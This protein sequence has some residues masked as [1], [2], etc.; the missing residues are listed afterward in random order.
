MAAFTPSSR[1]LTGFDMALTNAILFFLLS[2]S[3]VIFRLPLG[4]S[5]FVGVV[6][7]LGSIVSAGTMLFSGGA[8]AA[9]VFYVL[10]CG[11]FFGFGT[12]YSTTL[13]DFYTNAFFSHATQELMVPSMNLINSLSVTIALVVA[14]PFC[15]QGPGESGRYTKLRSTLDLLRPALPFA[16]VLSFIYI[17]LLIMTFPLA[18]DPLLRSLITYMQ[19]LA[20][21]AVLASAAI[22]S[23]ASIGTRIAASVIVGVLSAIGLI[24]F[25]KQQTM[26]P[27]VALI[28]GLLLDGQARRAAM[29]ASAAAVVVYMFLAVPVSTYGRVH[30]NYNPAENSIGERL[31]MFDYIFERNSTEHDQG[32]QRQGQYVARF[33]AAPVQAFLIAQH[34]KGNPGD[35][36][37]QGWIALVPRVLWSDKPNVTRFGTELDSSV[38][39]RG[40]SAS[41]LAPSYSGEAYWNGG[42]VGLILVSALLGLE[43]GWLTRKWIKFT[44]VGLREAGIFIFGVP[45][46][47]FSLWVETWIVPTY[48]GGFATLFV[49]ITAANFAVRNLLP[50]SH[51]A[52]ISASRRPA[53]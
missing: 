32:R 4:F 19:G 17:V 11:I 37:A 12:V 33:S 15:R 42:W 20:F 21:C 10:G 2:F 23:T 35:T 7:F 29:I 44:R 53:L 14:R 1:W 49:L 47:L 48:V 46:M 16:F 6:Y 3:V 9:I 27:L 41:A 24:A 22:W 36:L 30:P 34:D 50:G 31:A 40:N 25:S 5:K 13:N 18:H 45:A 51:P 39:R 52:T 28:A 43:V 38:F 8:L 26:L